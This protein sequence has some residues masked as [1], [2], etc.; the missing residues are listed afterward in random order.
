MYDWGE[1]QPRVNYL[2]GKLKALPPDDILRGGNISAAEMITEIEK[3]SSRG[4]E[5]VSVAGF[6]LQ[7]MAA[8]PERFQ[9]NES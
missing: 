1:R 2:L 3:G 6:V 9:K 8:T 4:R 5:F 7:A